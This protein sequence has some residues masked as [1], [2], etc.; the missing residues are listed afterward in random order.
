MELIVFASFWILCGIAAVA[1]QRGRGRTGE[2]WF[3]YTMVFGPVAL[4]M[5]LRE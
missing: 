5:A 3:L 4:I 2:G 1:I